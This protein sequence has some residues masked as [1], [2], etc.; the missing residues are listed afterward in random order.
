MD[1]RYEE[2]VLFYSYA[3]VSDCDELSLWLKEKCHSLSLLGRVRV[4]PEGVNGT[5]SGRAHAV[6]EFCLAAEAEHHEVFRG[7]DW[8]RSSNRGEVPV[9]IDL[10]VEERNEICSHGPLIPSG[11]AGPSYC[12]EHGGQ[13]LSP[14][15]FHKALEEAE[16]DQNSVV[17][18]VRNHYEAS[19]GHFEHPRLMN[20]KTRVFS[21]YPDWVKRNEDLLK[22]KRILMYCTGGIRC[23]KASAFIRAEGISDRV[24]QL[25]GG[26]HRYLEA[27]PEGGAFRGTNFVFDKRITLGAEE[28]CQAM[29]EVCSSSEASHQGA[30]VC[31]VCRDLV[32]CCDRCWARDDHGGPADLFCERHQSLHHC[33][34]TRL[35]RF[36]SEE[37]RD[38][39]S[40]LTQIHAKLMPVKQGGPSMG[41]RRQRKTLMNQIKRVE[42]AINGA[43]AL[44]DAVVISP[45]AGLWRADYTTA[46]LR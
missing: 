37:L 20:P 14:H 39:Y 44:D 17:I 10:K 35:A 9:F 46:G 3:L 8:K 11:E 6:D 13:H 41:S 4:A 12:K 21:E 15:A 29:C 36:S 40:A 25:E 34:R 7:T 26:I 42:A 32:L 23:E 2:V 24:E 31:C 22:G 45:T 18:D 1:S 28:G 27:F 33:Y 30:R 5:L 19:V 43:A 16:Q 38:Q